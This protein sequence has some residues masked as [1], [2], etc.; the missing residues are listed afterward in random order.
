MF[1]N[2]NVRERK[3]SVELRNKKLLHFTN[4]EF[5]VPKKIEI[6]MYVLT[7]HN[8]QQFTVSGKVWNFRFESLGHFLALLDYFI[9]I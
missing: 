7:A 1:I 5:I 8:L 6:K 2:M 3:N 9:F 4:L